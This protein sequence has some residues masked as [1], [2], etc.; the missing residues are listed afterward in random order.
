MEMVAAGAIDAMP[1]VPDSFG[2]SIR[3]SA[4]RLLFL[5]LVFLTCCAPTIAFAQ[6]GS[7]PPISLHSEN[8][9]YFLWRGKP[10]VL[11][12]AGEHYGALLNLDFDYNVYFAELEKHGLNSTRTFSGSYREVAASFGITDNT[13]A[14]GPGKFICPWARSETPGAGDG[15]AKFDLTRWDEAYFA[16]LKDFMAEAGKRGVVV[17]FVLFCPMYNQGMWSVCPMNVTNNINGIGNC[18]REELLTLKHDDLTRV[19]LALT[20]KI[21]EELKGFDNLYYEICNEP[22]AYDHVPMAFQHR[23]IDQIVEAEKNFPR[24]HLI[25]LNIANHRAKVTAPHPAVSIFNFH[26]CV[27][28]DVVA[29]NYGLNKVIGENETGFRGKADVFYRTEGWAFLLAGGALFNHLD[30]SFTPPHADGSS[31]DYRSP[32][33]G[34]PELRVQLGILKRFVEGFDFIR[35]RPDDSVIKMISGNLLHQTLSEPG[36]A[37]ALYLYPKMTMP[38]SRQQIAPPGEIET[39][40]TV[41]FP[42]GAYSVEWIDTKTGKVVSAESINQA[43]VSLKLKSPRFENDIALRILRR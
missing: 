6:A 24:Q 32:G 23:V 9:H 41:Q 12:T 3:N 33:G 27:P 34:S 35:M 16:R 19:Q 5:S 36:K 26:Y 42:I 2:R 11:V 21:V 39:E 17:E 13:L 28:P 8:P 31:R 38:F 10:A 4:L 37:Y 30:Y 40:L 14:P 22:Y 18:R 25:S 43:D 15:G 7:S 29:M 1:D 20:R